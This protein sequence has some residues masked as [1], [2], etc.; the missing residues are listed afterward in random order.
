L[1]SE[2][3]PVCFGF[4]SS[5]ATLPQCLLDKTLTE[6]ADRPPALW[7][8]AM[9]A[10][11]TESRFPAARALRRRLLRFRRDERGATVIEF[12]LVALPFFGLLFA[13]IETALVFFA[14]QAL[15]TAV[16]NA[17]RLIRTGQ[18]QSAGYTVSDFKTRSATR[19]R[20]SSTAAAS[21]SS[22]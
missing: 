8:N 5:A 9:A 20:R 10:G 16:S 15:E 11:L 17:A 4:S 7:R 3:L 19:S 6:P 1:V 2:A 13:I 18:A 22:M 21:C 12:G 14:G